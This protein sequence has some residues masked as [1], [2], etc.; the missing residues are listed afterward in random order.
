MRPFILIVMVISNSNNSH[1]KSGLPWPTKRWLLAN[2]GD[3]QDLER[4]AGAGGSRT[5][6]QK[7]FGTEGEANGG[8]R[9]VEQRPCR[10]RDR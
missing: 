4:S 8:R 10:P 2:Y 3:G 6:F 1:R 5:E 7:G 9:Q